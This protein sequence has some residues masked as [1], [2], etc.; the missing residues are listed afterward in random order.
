MVKECLPSG[1]SSWLLEVID[2]YSLAIG[3]SSV[4][5]LSTLYRTTVLG[6][7]THLVQNVTVVS[8][9]IGVGK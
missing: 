7:Q 2:V 4:E 5:G 6:I 8:G 3:Q 9:R 1:H